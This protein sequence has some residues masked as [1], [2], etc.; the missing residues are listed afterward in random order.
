MDINNHPI[1]GPHCRTRAIRRQIIAL[2][3]LTILK[4]LCNVYYDRTAI[5]C[6][7]VGNSEHILNLLCNLLATLAKKRRT[8]EKSFSFV[9]TS[10]QI[11]ILSSSNK[12]LFG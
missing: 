2:N 4:Y 6:V 11:T 10:P 8:Y 12:M 7:A 9:V 1:H 3:M 5:F